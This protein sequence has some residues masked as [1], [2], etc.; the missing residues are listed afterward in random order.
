[1]LERLEDPTLRILD[2]Q[3][4]L[5]D[6]AAGRAAYEAAHLPG[7]IY[8]HLD[9]DLSAPLHPDGHGGRHPLPD[10]EVFAERLGALGIGDEHEVVAYDDAG[11][12]FAGRL[13]W[14]LRWIGRPNVRILDGGL[15]AWRVLGGPLT[16][17][18][19][20]FPSAPSSARPV[21]RMVV[22]AETLRNRLEDPATVIVDARAAERY[23]GEVEPL[24]RKAGHVP[25][26]LNR[27][28]QGNLD[29]DGRFRTPE[30]LRARYAELVEAGE[31]V[32]YC[33]SGVTGAHDVLAIEE[34]GLGLPTLYAGSWSDWS[35]RDGFPVATGDETDERLA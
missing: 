8:L 23:R 24:D 18:V 26:A 28:F 17:D 20:S 15:A 5:T 6:P 7:A 27:P 31:V 19:P 25:G 2:V 32:V 4:T 16:R 30:A 22:D 35:S 13:W 1:L 29:S 10:P 33:G 11:G 34:A 12:A 21:E 9:E 14:L 3:F